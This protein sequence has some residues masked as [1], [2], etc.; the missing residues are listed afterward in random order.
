MA[1]KNDCMMQYFEW[2]LPSDSALWNKVR[3]DGTHLANLG[4]NYIWLPPAYKGAAG[5]NDVGYGVYDLYDLGEFDQK[6]AIPTKYGTKEEYLNAIKE[7]KENNIKVLA[8]IVLNHKMGADELEEVLAVQDDENDRNVSITTATPIKAWTKYTFP[9]RGNMY[10]DFKWD[11]T[12]FHGIDWDE[13]TKKASVYKFYGKKW[14]EDVDKEKGNFDYLMGADIDMNNNDVSNELIKWGKWYYDTTH[15]DG[16]R[17]DAVKHIRADFFPKWL[18]EIEWDLNDKKPIYT[19]GEY[20]S[21]DVEVMKKYIEKTDEKI[22]LFDVPLHYNMYKA[23]ISN[24]DYNLSEIFDG[25]L[26]KERPDLAVTF[27]DNHDTEP[28]QALESWIADWFKPHSYALI[29]LRESGTPCIFYGDYYGIPEKGVAPK[30]ELLDKLLKVRKYFAY[31]DQEDYLISRNV[32]GF[33]RKGDYEHADSGLAVVMSDKE[34]GSVTMNLGKAN[35]NSVFYDC[36]GN[37]E[38]KVY[39]DQNGDG[40]FSCKEGSVSVWIKDG[41]YVN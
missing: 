27:V 5:T 17:L 37:I 21:I 25:T 18:E 11:W 9:G 12:H 8:D 38:D 6:G 33:T 20:W 10:S 4:I 39:V 29:L 26:V 32:I 34:A 14:D 30:N 40:V 15:V 13:N 23:S 28:G 24:G 3:K 19:V 31:G 22:H 2:Y 1:N 36:L 16:F 41:Q 7:L 35:S